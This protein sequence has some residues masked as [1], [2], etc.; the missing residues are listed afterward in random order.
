MVE[1]EK[2]VLEKIEA[3]WS[4]VGDSGSTVSEKLWRA[5]FTMQRTSNCV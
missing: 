2:R 5:E 3:R 4:S 1:R